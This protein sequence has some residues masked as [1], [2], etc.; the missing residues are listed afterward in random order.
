MDIRNDIAKGLICFY[1]IYKDGD[2]TGLVFKDG[3][4]S[5]KYAQV[6]CYLKS[7]AYYYNTD[8]KSLS[9][10][11]AQRLGQSYS[12]PIPI[13]GQVWVPYYVRTP[14]IKGD[15]C[16]GY[17]ALS[18]IDKLRPA[19]SKVLL[20]MHPNFTI[21]INNSLSTANRRLNNARLLEKDLNNGNELEH[22]KAFLENVLSLLKK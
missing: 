8:L 12:N 11:V 10:H 14:K 4:R 22:F 1:P 18:C 5:I 16:T 13:S 19:G 6:R 20:M 17:F 9:K 7:L 2:N 15:T 21:K 3:S